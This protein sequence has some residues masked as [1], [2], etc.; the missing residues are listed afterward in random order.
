V[1]GNKLFTDCS[2]E[3]KLKARDRQ[4][5]LLCTLWPHDLPAPRS[6]PK[7]PTAEHRNIGGFRWT[8]QQTSSDPAGDELNRNRVIQCVIRLNQIIVGHVC[9]S[10]VK[11]YGNTATA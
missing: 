6:P 8:Y 10:K 1:F 9:V 2:L 5:R 7:R 4:Y 3:A 11:R